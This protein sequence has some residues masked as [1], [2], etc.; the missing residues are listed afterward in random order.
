MHDG[1]DP[2]APTIAVLCNEDSEAEVL[3]T[4]PDLYVDFVANSKWPGQGFKATF[5]FQPFDDSPPGTYMSSPTRA[6]PRGGCKRVY[7]A[8]RELFMARLTI[9][10]CRL[11]SFT[12]LLPAATPARAPPSLEFLAAG[13]EVLRKN[14]CA[15]RPLRDRG[16]KR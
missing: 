11:N 13:R 9:A 14:Y 2:T 7:Y 15:L 12:A 8:G 5:Q 10:P 1:S 4:G 16:G 6:R 3:S